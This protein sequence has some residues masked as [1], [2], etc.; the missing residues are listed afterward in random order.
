[1]IILN[2][3]MWLTIALI[4][5]VAVWTWFAG[6]R[7][8][9]A[10]ERF[11]ERPAARPEDHPEPAQPFAA[12]ADIEPAVAA[13]LDPGPAASTVPPSAV[14]DPGLAAAP[15]DPPPPAPP[16]DF[17]PPAPGAAPM[18]AAVDPGPAAS[19]SPPSATTPSAAPASTAEATVPA[20]TR[21]TTAETD[22]PGKPGILNYTIEDIEGIGP[23]YGRT[24]AE[25]GIDTTGRLLD[26]CDSARGRKEV[27]ERTGLTE[28][29]LLKWVN[30]ADLMRVSGVGEEWSE[31]LEAAGVDTVKELQHRNADNL[32]AKMAEV[33]DDKNLA[34]R[35]PSA[36]QVANW[37]EQAKTLEPR[38]TH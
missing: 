26:R 36:S 10:P 4:A 22:S 9:Q 34:R 28:T 32:A 1:M 24:L 7:G 33:N 5:A 6:R 37:V 18:A 30:M 27:A 38:I 29:Q 3:L 2:V 35:V 13:S 11:G 23:A 21:T 15:A 16:A 8:P 20:G 19:T 14:A 31:L 12:A 17:A 25:V